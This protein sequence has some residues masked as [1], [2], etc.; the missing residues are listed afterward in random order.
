MAFSGRLVGIGAILA[1]GLALAAYFAFGQEGDAANLG[2]VAKGPVD[3][4]KV[5]AYLPEGMKATYENSAYSERTGMTVLTNVRFAAHDDPDTGVEVGE[6]LIAGFDSAFIE[7]R[8]NSANFD[9]SAVVLD[10]LEARNISLFGMEKYYGPAA[11][12]Y[13]GAVNDLIEDATDEAV[14]EIEQ[15][16]EK[17]DFKIAR[18]RIDDF[19]MLPF[20]P[21]SINDDETEAGLATLQTFAAYSRAMGA[22]ALSIEGF[23]MDF[24]MRQNGEDIS[25]TMAMPILRL[26]GWQGG[27]YA[28]SSAENLSFNVIA[29]NDEADESF[30]LETIEM[31]GSVGSYLIENV[32]FDKVLGWLARGEMPPTTE[33]DLMSLGVLRM[34]DQTFSIFGT[35]FYAIDSSVTDMSQFHWLIPTRMTH[36]T[37]N[38][39]Y[40][41]GAL[42]DTVMKLS[43]ELAED[44]DFATFGKAM[45]LLADY[46]LSA[47]SMDVD[48]K[49]LWDQDKGPASLSMET[50]LDGYGTFAFDFSGLVGGFDSWVSGFAGREDKTQAE[51]FE[52]FA[53]RHFAFGGMRVTMND[54]GGNQR[55]F[56]LIVAMADIFKDENKEWETIAAY[57]EEAL[58]LLASSAIKGSAAFAGKELPEIHDYAKALADYIT[59]G[60][61]FT[62]ALAPEAPIQF[63]TLRKAGAIDSP[64][65][66]KAFLDELGLAV[67]YSGAN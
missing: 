67:T 15:S 31:S 42:L 23:S 45:T 33:T 43:P 65:E 35:P 9:N 56:D 50:G 59:E 26:E 32:R 47:P 48:F 29:P 20:T 54:R 49:W 4:E 66:G 38:L 37:D 46:D 53:G 34:K 36:E 52:A 27:N 64:Q 55:L 24:G 12:A 30:P 17:A 13:I 39:V 44:T 11:D 63:K 61:T 19:E 6:L 16:I 8:Q 21:P 62:I 18:I 10:H 22:K 1:G 40:D 2:A 51:A 14:P 57:D 3:I 25:M 28:R 7:A 41:I 60:G 5:F 58:K